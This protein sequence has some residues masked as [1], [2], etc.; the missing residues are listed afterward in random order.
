MAETFQTFVLIGLTTLH[1][2]ESKQRQLLS[3]W[4]ETVQSTLQQLVLFAA[5]NIADL[6]GTGGGS[7]SVQRDYKPPKG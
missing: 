7:A 2:C 1:A 3:R 6:H 4:L 5:T